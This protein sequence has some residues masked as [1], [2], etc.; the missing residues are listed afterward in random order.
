MRLFIKKLFCKHDYNFHDECIKCG[1]IY[2]G[3]GLSIIDSMRKKMYIRSKIIMS[4]ENCIYFSKKSSTC[5]INT[6][7]F[8]GFPKVDKSHWCSKFYS[9]SESYNKAMIQCEKEY[10]YNKVKEN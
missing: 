4:C 1:H 10:E 9:T 3:Y 5:R 7:T 2:S 6:P 8:S